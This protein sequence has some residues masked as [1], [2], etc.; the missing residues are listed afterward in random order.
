MDPPAPI[1]PPTPIDPA[2]EAA[3]TWPYTQAGSEE[4]T[5]TAAQQMTQM[6]LTRRNNTL[7]IAKHLSRLGKRPKPLVLKTA[8][9]Q[10]AIPFREAWLWQSL[11]DWA[12]YFAII[13]AHARD[14]LAARM[15][16]R[17]QLVQQRLVPIASTQQHHLLAPHP[18]RGR[19]QWQLRSAGCPSR[20]RIAVSREH[21]LDVMPSFLI[22][23]HA[24]V[25][26]DRLGTG[27]IGRQQI[28]QPLKIQTLA[29][30]GPQIIEKIRR[31]KDIAHRVKG[32]RH[33]E[34]A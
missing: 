2:P 14:K 16:D 28:G 32:I 17:G 27:V 15:P 19:P 7:S 21:A 3:P 24:A 29:D 30:S 10:S 4:A 1:E 9:I 23:R 11:A 5:T 18:R 34:L 26:L 20:Y 8:R 12:S 31:S 33:R 22:R 13:D 6:H 25:F